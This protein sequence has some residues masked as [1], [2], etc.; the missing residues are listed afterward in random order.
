MIHCKNCNFEIKEKDNFCKKCGAQLIEKRITLASLFSHLLV[1]L[2]WDSNFFVTLR[3]LVYKPQVVFDEYIN[4]TRKKYTNPFT[5]FAIITAISLFTF[6]HYSEEYIQMSANNSLQQTEVVENSSPDS[7]K[8]NEDL[9]MFGYKNE[10]EFKQGLLKFQL[11]YYNFFAFLFLPLYT[12]IAF[13]V[14]RKPY[15]FGEHLV[16]NTYLQSITTFL[17]LLLFVFSLLARINIFATGIM[18]LPFFYYCFGYKKL[19]KLGYAELIL[20]ILKFMA[21]LLIP[22]VILIIIGFFSAVIKE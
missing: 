7:V 22:L 10:N 8:E 1:A 20:K 15:N 4:G 16:I 12:L 17:S 11:K 9:E 5:F 21:I 3:Y 14:F 2:G 19:Y 18:L 6:S 13:F